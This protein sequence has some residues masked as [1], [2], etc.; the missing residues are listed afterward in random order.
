MKITELNRFKLNRLGH[1]NGKEIVGKIDARLI[2]QECLK[3]RFGYLAWSWA[4][5]GKFREF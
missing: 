1:V 5:N 4:G 3:H 2:M